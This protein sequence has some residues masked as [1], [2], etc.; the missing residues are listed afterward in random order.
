MEQV[1]SCAEK[2][3]CPLRP[4]AQSC[5]CFHQWMWVLGHLEDLQ[6][7]LGTSVNLAGMRKPGLVGWDCF[8]K[9]NTE[10]CWG[11]RKQKHVLHSVPKACE[12]YFIDTAPTSPPW[13]C[14][15][16]SSHSQHPWVPQ[17]EHRS[18]SQHKASPHS[19][20]TFT[21]SLEEVAV[22]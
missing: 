16:Q 6:E 5:H 9:K 10:G 13:V 22:S 15:P 7:T 3:C 14:S 17:E 8:G 4:R 20:L 18:H 1:M 19:C 11:R 12:P 2:A 21:G